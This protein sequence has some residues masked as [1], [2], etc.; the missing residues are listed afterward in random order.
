MVKT[1][2]TRMIGGLGLLLAAGG[3]GWMLRGSPQ[4]PPEAATAGSGAV[5]V[6]VARDPIEQ[7]VRARGIVKPAP[8]ALVRLGFPMPKDVSRRIRSLRVVEGDVVAAGM[9]LGELD[10]SDLAAT[11]QQLHGDAAVVQKKLDALR[12]LEP[13]EL[14]LAETVRDQAAAQADLADRNLTRGAQLRATLLSEQEYEALAADA[15]VARARLANAE[16][17]LSQLRTRFSTDIATL[18]AQLEQTKAAIRN[19]EVQLEWGALRAPFDAVVFAVHQRPGELSSNQP[20][21][22]VLTLLKANELQPHLYVD[23][24]DFGKVRIGQNV[25]LQLEAHPGERVTGTVVRL[26]PQPVLQENVVY[27]LALV[28]VDDAYRD[29]LRA[30]MTTLAFVETGSNERV[31][32]VPSAAVYSKPDGWYV[33]RPGPNGPVETPVQIGIRNEGRVEIRGGVTEGTEILVSQ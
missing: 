24:T 28:N 22:P 23:E 27:Y 19:L 13:R 30:E 4:V 14:H 25:T 26:L 33:R 6:R 21:A 29:L 1:R 31:L 3:V 20:G 17:T 16:A 12:A 10:T 18:E 9:L 32:W 2:A 7:T 5:V 8:N 15:K 11:L